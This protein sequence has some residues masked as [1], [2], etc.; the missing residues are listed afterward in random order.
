M[1]VRSAR[2]GDAAGCA[3][4]YAPYVTGTAVSFEL[5]P[6]DAAQMLRRM[7]RSYEWLVAE[8]DGEV[9]GYAYGGP[10]RERAAYR[11]AAET[12]VYLR[13]DSR[14]RGLGSALYTELIGRLERRGL[15]TLVAGITL[16]NPASVALHGSFGFETVG[17]WRR[18]GW[19]FDA[20]HDV[21]RGQRFLAAGDDPP[22][23]PDLSPAV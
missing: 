23:E 15:R 6:P 18:V 1:L 8:A 22:P 7:A 10:Y 19:K 13:A 20:W 17:V 12:S 21:W 3:A 11:W 5:T 14:G 4:I 9:L 16:P 2:A